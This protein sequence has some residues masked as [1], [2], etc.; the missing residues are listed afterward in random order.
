MSP[1]PCPSPDRFLIQMTSV[2]CS[3]SVLVGVQ[4]GRG[5]DGKGG[6]RKGCDKGR[7]RIA[8]KEI[9]MQYEEGGV[10]KPI[11]VSEENRRTDKDSDK[12]AD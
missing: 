8:P 11:R 6:K 1:H 2:Y 4:G 5:S 12:R 3:R 9:T 7:G 10:Q